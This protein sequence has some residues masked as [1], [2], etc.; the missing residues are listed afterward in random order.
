MPWVR[1]V[2][3]RGA[4]LRHKRRDSSHP[5]S[6]PTGQVSRDA[7]PDAEVY[8]QLLNASTDPGEFSP[9]F[10]ELQ[11]KF[12][13]R[14][15]AKLKNLLRLVKY[16]YK[17]VRGCPAS[18]APTGHP[19]WPALTLVPIF[20]PAAEATAPHCRPAP[21]VCP[22]AADHLCL[23]GGHGLPR[24]LCHSRGLPYGAGAAVPVPGDLHLLG[25]VL[26]APA[27][28]DRRARQEAAV[29]SLV[30][31]VPGGTHAT[32]PAALPRADSSARPLCLQPCHPGPRRPHGDPGPTQELGPGGT[33]SCP[34]PFIALRQDRPAL[35][36]EGKAACACGHH[37]PPPP[38]PALPTRFSVSAAGPTRD[39]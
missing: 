20:S 15:P 28:P 37:G 27:Q 7:P 17:E 33:G 8:V 3:W 19:P 21:Q 30:R 9:C 25:D 2:G 6:R 4:G 31:T 39:D 12:V 11:K 10:T 34:P 35:G 16:W 32:R 38:L 5:P 18:P 29:Q 24:L 14:Y 1:A 22:G 23:G 36:C 13:K 26:L